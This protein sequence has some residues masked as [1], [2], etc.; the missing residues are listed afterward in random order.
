MDTT[1]PN[2]Q[3]IRGSQPEHRTL[4]HR[5]A[6]SVIPQ[7]VTPQSEA[8]Q[9]VSPQSEPSQTV[10]P[11]S[12]S[13]QTQSDLENSQL[14]SV[15]PQSIQKLS[16]AAKRA[17]D[18]TASMTN[19]V[20]Q[21]GRNLVARRNLR[22]LINK[23]ETKEMWLDDE[24]INCYFGQ[25]MARENANRDFPKLYCFTSHFFKSA[26]PDLCARNKKLFD[27]NVLLI[28]V[29]VINRLV[30]TSIKAYCSKLKL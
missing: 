13:R 4:S 2:K 15:P 10:S 27:I 12:S 7:S 6:Q 21:C 8:H 25:L 5:Q 26:F 3:P 23:Q 16:K 24:E 9:S 17:I 19:V 1:N 11:Q 30:N 29:N 18:P 28:P 20:A 14:K 22:R